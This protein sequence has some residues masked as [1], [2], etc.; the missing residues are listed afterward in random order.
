MPLITGTGGT[1]GSCVT[2][3]GVVAHAVGELTWRTSVVIGVAA[4]ALGGVPV[5]VVGVEPQPPATVSVATMMSA[6]VP[7]MAVASV[8]GADETRL[9]SRHPGVVPE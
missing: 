5:G 9:C 7:F 4:A 6:L 1:G 8:E 2:V 3:T